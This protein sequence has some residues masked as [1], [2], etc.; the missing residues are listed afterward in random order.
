VFKLKGDLV[1]TIKPLMWAQLGA[2][3]AVDSTLRDNTLIGHR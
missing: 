1:S 2:G 3:R